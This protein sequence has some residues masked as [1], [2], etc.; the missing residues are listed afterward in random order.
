MKVKG[1]DCRKRL[2]LSSLHGTCVHSACQ[3]STTRLGICGPHVTAGN[4]DAAQTLDGGE[5]GRARGRPSGHSARPGLSPRHEPVQL[6]E[7]GLSGSRSRARPSCPVQGI[8][9]VPS[10]ATVDSLAR[11]EARSAAA[12]WLGVAGGPHRHPRARH[13]VTEAEGTSATG[14]VSLWSLTSLLSQGQ[15]SCLA[16]AD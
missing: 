12:E 10:G 6:R 7:R 13:S 15:S 5:G 4:S 16:D 1:D 14:F 3:N 2:A 11:R 9:G 8:R